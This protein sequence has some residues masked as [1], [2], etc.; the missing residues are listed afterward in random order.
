MLNLRR[1]KWM[2]FADTLYNVQE[3]STPTFLQHY[4][5]YVTQSRDSRDLVFLGAQIKRTDTA[6]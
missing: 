1:S 3:Y 2:Y 6:T 4:N 5:L